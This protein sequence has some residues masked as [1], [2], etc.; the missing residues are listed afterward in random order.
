MGHIFVP[1]RGPDDWRR[2]LSDPEKHWADR[3]SAKML[4]ETWESAGGFPPAVKKAFE[5]SGISL[6]ADIEPLLIVPEYK[7]PLPG[8]QRPS[9]SDVFVLA[10]AGGELVAIAVEGKVE[11]PFG[12]TVA[13]WLVDTS[14][15]KQERLAFLCET[16]GLARDEVGPIRYQLLHRAASAVIEAR[17]FNAAHAVMLVHSFSQTRTWFEDYAAFAS[18]LGAQ[19]SHDKGKVA[20][21]GSR[22]SV[23]LY[24]GWV[25]GEEHGA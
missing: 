4:A 3:Y 22:G 9:Q 1:S 24:L 19:V 23:R 7:T 5:R 15:G 2:L 20:D 12:P 21:A 16:L 13:E 17:R 14:P 8:G 18:L 11:E 10:R 6:F 25:T